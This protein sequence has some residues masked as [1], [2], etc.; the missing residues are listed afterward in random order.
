M[1]P[2][3]QSQVRLVD[4]GRMRLI[5]GRSAR[6]IFLNLRGDAVVDRFDIFRGAATAVD[7][8]LDINKL[9]C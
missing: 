1:P 2:I 8:R 7:M 5:S 3:E 9:I 4:P 6:V